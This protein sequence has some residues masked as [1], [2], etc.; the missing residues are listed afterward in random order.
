MFVDIEQRY[1]ETVRLATHTFASLRF[2]SPD[3]TV[4]LMRADVLS[5]HCVEEPRLQ[6]FV[7]EGPMGQ[8]F[9]SSLPTLAN[10]EELFD[11]ALRPTFEFTT[12]LTRELLFIQG[13]DLGQG[14]R[15]VGG[16]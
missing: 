13:P 7:S 10:C 5:Q 9:G 14:G 8:G 15:E 1:L 12:R 6:V 16:V 4:L 3:D 2:A 11:L